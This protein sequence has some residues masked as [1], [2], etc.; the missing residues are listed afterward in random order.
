MAADAQL[1]ATVA[2]LL[3]RIK[4]HP[5]TLPGPQPYPVR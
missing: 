2:T 5:G 4:G 3:A 1:E